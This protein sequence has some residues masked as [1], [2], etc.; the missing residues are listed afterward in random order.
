V[1]GLTLISAD[2]MGQR[3]ELLKQTV[4]PLS[5]LACL[6]GPLGL[7]SWTNMANTVLDVESLHS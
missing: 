5:R 7:A 6:T 2:L 1:T 3:L 4:P